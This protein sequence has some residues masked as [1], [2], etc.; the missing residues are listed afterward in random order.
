MV[1][2]TNKAGLNYLREKKFRICRDRAG[3]LRLQC[4]YKQGFYKSKEIC[5]EN[6]ISFTCRR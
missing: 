1:P 3:T 4:K 2:G 5:K 6:A